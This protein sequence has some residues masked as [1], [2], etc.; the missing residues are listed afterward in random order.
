MEMAGQRKEPK[1]CEVL[2]LF[3]AVSNKQ[4]S[5]VAV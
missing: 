2:T 3:N 5:G 4:I 1:L